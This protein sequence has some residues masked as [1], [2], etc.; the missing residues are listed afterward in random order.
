M[1]AIL[2]QDLKMILIV[3]SATLTAM[4]VDHALDDAQAFAAITGHSPAFVAAE[5]SRLPVFGD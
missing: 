2:I 4:L 1:G 5:G 3:A